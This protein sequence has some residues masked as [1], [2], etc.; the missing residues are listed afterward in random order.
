MDLNEQLVNDNNEAKYERFG[1]DVSHADA[2]TLDESAVQISRMRN[3]SLCSR[4]AARF[5]TCGRRE[6]IEVFLII[7]ITILVLVVIVM[8]TTGHW[9]EKDG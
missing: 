1:N 2:V 6:L 3:R 4:C 7:M 8:G 9:G 5:S